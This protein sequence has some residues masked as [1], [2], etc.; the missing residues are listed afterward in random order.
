MKYT[1]YAST[2]TMNSCPL[3]IVG[4]YKVEEMVHGPAAWYSKKIEAY[5]PT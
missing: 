4:I 1:I 5:V 3:S 2:M